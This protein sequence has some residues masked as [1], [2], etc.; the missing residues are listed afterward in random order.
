MQEGGGGVVRAGLVTASGPN[1]GSGDRQ[2]QQEGFADL[3]VFVLRLH[4]D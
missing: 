3:C 2:A 1:V 4:S